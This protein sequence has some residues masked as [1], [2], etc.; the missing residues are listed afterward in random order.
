[1][2]NQALVAANE[3]MNVFNR[4]DPAGVSAARKV[5]EKVFGEGWEDMGPRVYDEAPAQVWGI[6]A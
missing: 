2:Q 6:G 4:G 3:I 1:M 5:A